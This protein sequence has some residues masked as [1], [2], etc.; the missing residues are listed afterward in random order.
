MWSDIQRDF[1]WVSGVWRDVPPGRRWVPGHWAKVAA[2]FE[3]VSGFWAGEQAQEVQLLPHPPASLEVG[4]SSPA[5]GDN[6]FWVP[7]VWVWQNGAYGWRAGY[8]YLGQPNWVWVPDHY[9]YTP[10]GSFFVSGYW[11]FPLVRRG[12]L[13]APVYV[14][15]QYF[16]F[17]GWTYRPYSVINTSLL[18]TSLFIHDRHHHYYFGHG[19]WRGNHFHPWWEHDRRHGHRGY[20]P[21]WAYHRWH[22][23]R[24]RDGWEDHW[25]KDFDRRHDGDHRP[26]PGGGRDGRPGGE[27]LAG[28]QRHL[29]RRLDQMK[30]DDLPGVELRRMNAAEVQKTQRQIS[31]WKDLREARAKFETRVAANGDAGR[32]PIGGV[33]GG[34]VQAG[35]RASNGRV[36]RGPD[37]QIQIG[38]SGQAG[39]TSQPGAGQTRATAQA[40]ANV[41]AQGPSQ[42]Q[43]G[44]P[45]DRRRA[46]FKL[47]Q[48]ESTTGGSGSATAGTTEAPDRGSWSGRFQ[49]R[50]GG[51]VVVPGAGKAGTPQRFEQSNGGQPRIWQ[52]GQANVQQGGAAQ[53]G[54]QSAGRPNWSY[55]GGTGPS[56]YR[57]QIQ[58][59]GS[60]QFP[61]GGG[62]SIYRGS[63]QPSVDRSSQQFPS[64][65]AQVYQGG[66][67]SY[68]GSFEGGSQQFN[69]GNYSGGGQPSYQR[70]YSPSTR[71]SF[72]GT[73]RSSQQF[74]RGNWSGGGGG[75][76]SFRSS[77]G[78]GQPS[79]QSGGGGRSGGSIRF[80]GGG[81]GRGGGRGGDND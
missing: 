34:R 16:G 77:G 50:P 70:S 51:N 19:H 39:A 18:L 23:G 37:S 52:G 38:A 75:R 35:D 74:N 56:Q 21:L 26:G 27:Q 8:W 42:G 40:G 25:R 73:G 55:R 9:C 49:S 69:R 67:P 47:P 64:G 63:G 3:W 29:V 24:N 7:G 46:T 48:A 53:G 14:P 5:P 58:Q 68:R 78:G 41:Q 32:L 30:R 79:F 2:G 80:G 15:R 10:S 36:D 66:R 81:G 72:Q 57:S 44:S 20:D 12:L 43:L 17:P 31:Q 61:Q 60:P 1:V 22:D 11:D 13:F 71:Q 65:R 4:P 62:Q 76:Q 6:Y 33:G 45:F 54:D 59:G 28:D